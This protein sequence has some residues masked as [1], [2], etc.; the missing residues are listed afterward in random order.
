MRFSFLP[1]LAVAQITLREMLRQ[2]VLL[3]AMLFA[4]LLIG[5]ACFFSQFSMDDQAKFIKDWGHGVI[6]TTAL[7]IALMGAGWLIPSEI[8]RRTLHTTL[9]KPIRP[10]QFILGKY[11]GLVGAI[12]IVMLFLACI[13]SLILVYKHLHFPMDPSAVNSAQLSDNQVLAPNHTAFLDP[14]LLYAFCLIW[15]KI[16]LLAAVAILF[17][18]IATSTLFILALTLCVYFI[19]HLQSI[20]QEFWGRADAGFAAFWFAKIIR[21]LFPDFSVYHCI[22]SILAGQALSW[23]ALG[24]LTGYSTLYIAIL[25]CISMLLFE[26]REL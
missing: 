10:S 11:I 13:F 23:Q 21:A 9:T 8:E 25:L 20:L 14:S 3:V 2:R 7:L 16:C 1:I 22:D 12:T 15:L 26:G 18:T 17:S 6:S 19:G 4:L 24:G 5:G